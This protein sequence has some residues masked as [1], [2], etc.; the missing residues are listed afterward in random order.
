MELISE[1]TT[2]EYKGKSAVVYRDRELDIEEYTANGETEVTYMF[3]RYNNEVTHS[4]LNPEYGCSSP[5]TTAYF[6]YI[7]VNNSIPTF[8][9]SA[10]SKH[11]LYFNVLDED[12][13]DTAMK[14]V[15]DIPNHK[16]TY[17]LNLQEFGAYIFKK[18]AIESDPYLMEMYI[19]LEIHR[20]IDKKHLLIIDHDQNEFYAVDTHYKQ[21]LTGKNNKDG[22]L[23]SYIQDGER[24]TFRYND[25]GEMIYCNTF[26][27]KY[28]TYIFITN[29]N[30][31]I[32]HRI[33]YTKTSYGIILSDPDHILYHTRYRET[34][35]DEQEIETTIRMLTKEE[36]ENFMEFLEYNEKL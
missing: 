32:T 36:S 27:G 5:F 13:H 12:G 19:V 30:S 3:H 21:V 1:T 15:A 18:E 6:E 4:H 26:S 29:T 20:T 11:G 34:N 16:E 2:T 9:V 14:F 8:T 35:E 22:T 28:D 25:K 17:C 7:A 24:Y 23:D 31:N 33:P 10:D